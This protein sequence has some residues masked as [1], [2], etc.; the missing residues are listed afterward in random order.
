MKI[1]KETLRKGANMMKETV[2]RTSFVYY[3]IDYIILT[4]GFIYVHMKSE[5]P[6]S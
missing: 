2:N 3:L 1:D 5:L 6:W 4:L